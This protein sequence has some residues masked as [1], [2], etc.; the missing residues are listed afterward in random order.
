MMPNAIIDAQLHLFSQ[1]NKNKVQHCFF[2]SCD[3]F[4]LALASCDADGIVNIT[5]AFVNKMIKMRCNMAFWYSDVISIG[6]M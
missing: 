5:T 1:D 3:A 4:G 2:W 6:V